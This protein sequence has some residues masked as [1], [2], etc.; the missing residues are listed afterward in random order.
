MIN[1]DVSKTI[2]TRGWYHGRHQLVTWRRLSAVHP[3]KCS[4]KAS[5]ASQS[6]RPNVSVTVT[7]LQ[8]SEPGGVSGV[9]HHVPVQVRCAIG[10]PGLATFAEGGLGL[11]YPLPRRG[12]S[13]RSCARMATPLTQRVSSVRGGRVSSTR[14]I[15][16]ASVAC[17]P[18]FGVESMISGFTPSMYPDNCDDRAD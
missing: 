10:P 5:D 1:D 14:A 2:R 18:V 9:L 13:G 7:V 11:F 16:R 12:A 8:C 3:N 4:I 6:M 17:S 15:R